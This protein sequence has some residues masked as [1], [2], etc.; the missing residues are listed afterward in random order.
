MIQYRIEQRKIE[1]YRFKP[2][3][4]AQRIALNRIT[5]N[6]ITRNYTNNAPLC[7]NSGQLEKNEHPFGRSKRTLG[8]V[9]CSQ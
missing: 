3:E 4:T 1:S 8:M 7:S 9:N 2:S 6:R 5:L